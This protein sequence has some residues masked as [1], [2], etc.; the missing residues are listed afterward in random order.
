MGCWC[1]NVNCIYDGLINGANQ[2]LEFNGKVLGTIGYRD[3]I[4][5]DSTNKVRINFD[6]GGGSKNMTGNMQFKSATSNLYNVDLAVNSENITNS[7]F[8]GGFK[9]AG[10]PDAATSGYIKGEYYG[11][12]TLKSIGGNFQVDQH[13]ATANGVFKATKKKKKKFLYQY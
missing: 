1:K 2:S 4:L 7:S 6:I 5:M 3:S 12:S 13:G 10:N 9:P 8:S 11:G